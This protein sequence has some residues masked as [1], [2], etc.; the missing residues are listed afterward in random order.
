MYMPSRV[1]NNSESSVIVF[2]TPY[3]KIGKIKFIEI[4][5]QSASD[6]N[7]SIIDVFTPDKTLSNP[8]PSQ[9]EIPRKVITVKSGDD[10]SWDD[11]S[12]S[13]DIIGVCTVEFSVADTAVTATIG[14][15]FE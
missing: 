14:Y 7:V 2:S 8:Q 9:V 15:S 12:N 5:N 6:V 10:I 13:V 3:D 4:D 1:I 11:K